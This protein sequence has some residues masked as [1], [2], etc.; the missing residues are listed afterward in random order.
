MEG[1]SVA[2]KVPPVAGSGRSL[3]TSPCRVGQRPVHMAMCEGTVHGAAETAWWKTTA[4][5]AKRSRCGV[6][7]VGAGPRPVRS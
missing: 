1:S 4:S 5:R 6:N 2:S 3:F 7:G